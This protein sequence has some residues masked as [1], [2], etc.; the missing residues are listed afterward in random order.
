MTSI[1]FFQSTVK[2]WG[3]LDQCIR[4]RQRCNSRCTSWR[5][6]FP[7]FAPKS[8]SWRVLGHN[9]D[10]LTVGMVVYW[11]ISKWIK[12][13][14]NVGSGPDIHPLAISTLLTARCIHIIWND[15]KPYSIR[16]CNADF[17]TIFTSHGDTTAYTWPRDKLNYS[18]LFRWALS[19]D[20]IVKRK[21][22]KKQTNKK[23]K[24]KGEREIIKLNF[25]RTKL[26]YLKVIQ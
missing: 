5:C 9:I 21:S 6:N 14:R 2:W 11:I 24:K 20:V 22:R 8:W 1:S 4:L 12:T 3:Q 26:M 25:I 16:E 13:Y 17:D 23:A 18:I 7:S 15:N 10:Q 19:I